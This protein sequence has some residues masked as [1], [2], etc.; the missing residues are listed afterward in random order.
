MHVPIHHTKM[1]QLKLKLPRFSW[2]Y[3]I[4]AAAKDVPKVA[5]PGESV[6]ELVRFGWILISPGKEAG[7]NK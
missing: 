5:Q 3:T 1:A 2:P 4:I 7:I 6:A